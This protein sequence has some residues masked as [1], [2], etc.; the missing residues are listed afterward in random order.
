MRCYDGT[1]NSEEMLLADICR[2]ATS[3]CSGSDVQLWCHGRARGASGHSRKTPRPTWAS[4]GKHDAVDVGAPWSRS[5]H[6][7]GL[8]GNPVHPF[9]LRPASPCARRHDSGKTCGR[10]PPPTRERKIRR[11]LECAVGP[12]KRGIG[13]VCGWRWQRLPAFRRM[14]APV[15]HPACRRRTVRRRPQSLGVGGVATWRRA[16]CTTLK[17]APHSVYHG[18]MALARHERWLD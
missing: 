11:R 7:T 18:D 12:G 17:R 5:I 3:A 8:W 4:N 13:I 14:P 6:E 2:F 9:M 10:S 16:D 15:T 1:I